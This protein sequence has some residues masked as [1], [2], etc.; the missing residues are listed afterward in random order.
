MNFFE[1]TLRRR[2]LF[3][4][5][6]LSEGAPIGFLWLAMPTRLRI[7]GVPIE[8]ITWLTAIL[9]LPWTFKFAW[10]PL[11][12][13][14]RSRWWTL[15]HWIVASQTIMGLTLAPLIWLDP[16]N[17]FQT[18]TWILLAHALSAATQDVAIDA[19][20]ISATAPGE[21]GQYNGWM[22]AGMLLG[23]SMMGGGALVLAAYV[24][25]AAI[26]G[27]LMMLTTF[28]M[29]LGDHVASAANGR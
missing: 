18:M 21:R 25:D 27:L 4:C 28:S 7:T 12:D 5:L 2:I 23:R 20:C 1:T 19:L 14:L 10:A 8:Q 26:V 6:Y 24:G 15:R 9:V 16:V 3:G 13:L 17:Q 11:V 22:Q 29:V